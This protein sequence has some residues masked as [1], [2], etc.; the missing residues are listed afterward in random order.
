MLPAPPRYFPIRNG[1]YD[2]A[3][4]LRPLG[5]DFGNG[6][7]DARAFQIDR[8]FPEFRENRLRCRRERP[9]KYVARQGYSEEVAAAVAGFFIH[10]LCREYPERFLREEAPDGRVA[11]RCRLTRERL[12]FDPDLRLIGGRSEA[13]PP[14]A[15]AFDALC[16][17]VQEDV[18]IISSP[19]NPTPRRPNAPAPQRLAA[20]HVCAPSHW[21][22]EEKLGQDFASIHAPVPGIEP[23]NRVAGAMVD[24]M[25]NRGPWVRFV[26]GIETTPRLNHH[27]EPPPGEEP[28]ER[29]VFDP[30]REEPF[31]LR[32]ERQ[33]TR[34]L[35][36]VGAAVFLIRLH[37]VPGS[38]IRS[39]PAEREALR[40]AILSMSPESRAYKGIAGH[41]DA[42]VEWLSGPGA[43]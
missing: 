12:L 1:R 43:R 18:A 23:V 19:T 5:T 36:D 35:P 8:R 39:R 21:V 16:C 37:H 33:V 17:Q 25:V 14:Y 29:A 27:P 20:Y 10:Q 15:D 3:P 28:R 11:L 40:S 7:M 31:L 26:W 2:V 24:A 13:N 42:L 9:G 34:G 4:A 32:V 41:A 30:T 38:E 6:D 22:P